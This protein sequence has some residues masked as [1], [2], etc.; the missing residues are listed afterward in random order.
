MGLASRAHELLAEQLRSATTKY[1]PVQCSPAGAVC[2]GCCPDHRGQARQMV[3][4]MGLNGCRLMARSLSLELNVGDQLKQPCS[5]RD[6]GFWAVFGFPL[7]GL[8]RAWWISVDGR[9][10]R[11]LHGVAETLCALA[12]GSA[13]SGRICVP[14][15]AGDRRRV[16]GPAGAACRRRSPARSSG[17]PV[18]A[19]GA[20]VWSIP[21]F[22]S[23]TGRCVRNEEICIMNT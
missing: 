15:A 22:P 19:S 23:R 5:L 10:C 13:S 17:R 9:V 1:R 3:E 20:T 2:P 4:T 12:Q 18:W 7:A 8:D 16:G 21:T 11:E 6:N 14:R